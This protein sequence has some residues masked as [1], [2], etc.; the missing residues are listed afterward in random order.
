MGHWAK[1]D[2]N[3]VVSKVLVADDDKH[4]WLVESFGGRWVQT[5][6]NTYGGVHYEPGTQNPSS[7]QS[8]ALRFNFAAIGSIYDEA[9]DAFLPSKPFNSWVLDEGTCLWQAPIPYPND[10]N[11]YRWDDEAIKWVLEE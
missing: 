9:R 10:G 1:L 3:N 2:E 4:D 8:K 11:N 5:S 6:Y 7:D